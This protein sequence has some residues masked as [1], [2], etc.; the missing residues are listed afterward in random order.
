MLDLNNKTI[1]VTG[2]C[3]FIATNFIEMVVHEYPTCKIWAI[4]KNMN[5]NMQV[6][7]NSSNVTYWEACVEEI[8]IFDVC[9][10]MKYN[11]NIDYIFNFAAESHVDNSINSAKDFLS[12]YS[13]T[14]NLLDI[15]VHLSEIGK[16]SQMVQISTDEVYGHHTDMGTTSVEDSP[17][18]PRNPY[19]AS[20]AGC[21]LLVESYVQT[22]D[23]DVLVTR[24]TNNFGKYQF[25]EKFIP[26]IINSLKSNNNIPVYGTGQN[27]REW[28]DVRDHNKSIL[29][30]LTNHKRG[31]YNVYGGTP[32][33]NLELISDILEVYNTLSD[34]D[35]PKT[36][37]KDVK[38]VADRKGHDMIYSITSKRYNRSFDLT[39]YE[40]S[41]EDLVKYN[42]KNETVDN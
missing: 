33:T 6:W 20:K 18:C 4:D 26:T 8:E 2:C 13:S 32:K 37:K 30:I 17:L 22:H 15:V 19:S 23:I 9:V 3:G 21:D 25:S 1:L 35:L 42:M 27:V 5:K 40:E 24:C 31:V 29:D 39:P 7:D 41:L 14:M 36:I 16:P 10:Y 11:G 28:I 38:F 12:N 34:D